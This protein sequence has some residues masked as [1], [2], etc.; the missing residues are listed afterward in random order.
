[1]SITFHLNTRGTSVN[2]HFVHTGMSA[3]EERK[4]VAEMLKAQLGLK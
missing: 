3:E 1:M 2:G 4:H